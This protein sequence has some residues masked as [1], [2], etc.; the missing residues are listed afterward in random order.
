MCNESLS[1]V[2]MSRMGAILLGAMAFIGQLVG[3]HA[4]AAEAAKPSNAWRIECDGKA[5]SAGTIQ[6]RV[7][8]AK[9]E[10]LVVTANIV[11]GR[12]ENGVAKDI[13]DAFKA[14]LPKDRFKAETDDGE[15][16]LVKRK[17]GEP[18]FVVDLVSSDIQHLRLNLERE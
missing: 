14:Q 9:G 18:D 6:F 11:E 4:D 17:R 3:Q 16:V 5:E 15:D 13:R 12:S 7:I 2:R 10:P 8:P 1:R